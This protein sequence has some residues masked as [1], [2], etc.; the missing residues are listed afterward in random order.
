MDPFVEGQSWRDFHASMML[1]MRKFLV[2]QLRPRYIVQVEEY[3]YLAND[4]ATRERLVIP[5][6]RVVETPDWQQSSSTSSET[7]L[8]PVTRESVLPE[9][10][11]QTYLEIRTSDNEKVLT[12]VECLSPWN[13]DPGAGRTE[14]LRKRYQV[15]MSPAALVEV[16]LLRGGQRVPT[17]VPLPEGDFFAFVTRREQ[18]PQMDV[19]A[20]T[21]RDK[22]PKIPIPL[23]EGDSDAIIDLQL[24]FDTVYDD[25]GYDYS[26]KYRKPP[27]PR[28]SPTNAAWVQQILDKTRA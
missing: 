7:L 11:E 18:F 23:G 13:K 4:E 5:D 8:A 19:F 2:A 1:T 25:G 27:T 28:L 3:V 9:T 22:L 21:L 10:Y 17:T 6:V 14:Y 15:A 16:D 12:V 24:V 20:W 26:L